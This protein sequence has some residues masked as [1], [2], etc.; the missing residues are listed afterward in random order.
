M[1][2]LED[3][4]STG[5]CLSSRT[6]ALWCSWRLQ[7]R[8]V[9]SW[10]GLKSTDALPSALHTQMPGMASASEHKNAKPLHVL[11]VDMLL[12]ESQL[13]FS[14]SSTDSVT[15]QMSFSA[16]STNIMLGSIKR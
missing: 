3:C 6:G 8:A 9:I 12:C 11:H 13:Y 1:S 4:P 5:L 7:E 14:L 10:T 2:P 16:S 15:K